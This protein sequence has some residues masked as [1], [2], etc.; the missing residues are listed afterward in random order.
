MKEAIGIFDSGIGGLT[1]LKEIIKILPHE[2]IIYL[3]DTARVPYGI[4]SPETILKYSYANA[5]FLMN[6]RIKILVIACNTASSI[7]TERLRVRCKIPVIEVITP[8]AKGAS[9]VTKRG[10]IGVIGTE[11]TI[12]SG[13][14]LRAIKAFN[15]QFEVYLKACPLFVPLVEEGWTDENNEVSLMVAEKYLGEL[16]RKRV[17]TLVLGCTH[18]PLLKGVIRKVMG[19]DIHLIDSA[20]ETAKEVL[21]VLSEKKLLSINRE[22]GGLQFFVTDDPERFKTMG[23]RFLEIELE[24]VKRVETI[25]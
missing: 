1:V 10:K 2:D 12:R 9:E 17:D 14:Y 24:K 13:T 15:P 4:R 6:Q 23:F 25:T 21:K 19:N 11:T 8:G 7:S 5:E 22:R 18:Y 16:R 3:G 20:Q